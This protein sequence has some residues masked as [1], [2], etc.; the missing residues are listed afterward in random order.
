[1]YIGTFLMINVIFHVRGEKIDYLIDGLE[2]NG[3]IFIG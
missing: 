2:T 1:M 3:Y